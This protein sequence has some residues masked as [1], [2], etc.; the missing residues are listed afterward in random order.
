MLWLYRLL[1]LP[2][3]LVCAPYYLLRMRR[4]GGYRR[5]FTQRLGSV[6]SLPEKPVGVRRIWIQAVS[7]GEMLAIGPLLEAFKNDRSVEFYLT[8]TTSTGFKIAK[9]RYQ[10]HTIAMGYFP[11]DWW[12]FSSRAWKKIKPDLIIL[13]EG[14]RWPEH[15]NQAVMR[16]VRVLALNARLSDRSFQRMR[17]LRWAASP[18]MAGITRVLACSEFDAQ[19]FREL[20]FSASAITT[21]G[22]IKLDLQL[23]P[24]P[25]AEIDRLRSELGLGRELVL[26]G[27]STWRGEEAALLKT[28]RRVREAG[29]GCRLL[30]VP[31][32]AERRSELEV[33]LKDSGLTYHFR[34]RGSAERTVDV[35]IADTTGELR[36]LTQIADLVFVGKSLPPH[37][38]GQTPVEAA[39]LGKPILFGPGMSNFRALA[40]ELVRVGAARRVHN[41]RELEEVSVELLKNSAARDAMAKA[42]REWHRANQGA[43]TRTI[44]VL[45]EELTA[46]QKNQQLVGV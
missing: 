15:V 38:Q 18:L 40:N 32:H 35:A 11:I 22:N 5:H 23:P 7:V 20:G 37:E 17:R 16:G 45:R 2:A 29:V 4:R 33:L 27:S 9:E 44:E 10:E 31:R 30:L 28:L 26:I 6:E 12:A 19:R 34:T 43:I 25:T 41:A 36:L 8:T 21:T 3:L 46:A 24:A 1:F 14:E 13:T 42:A 39:A